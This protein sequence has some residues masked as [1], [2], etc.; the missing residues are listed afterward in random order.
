MDNIEILTVEESGDRIDALLA[1]NLPQFSRSQIQKL[2]EQGSVSID[3]APLKK[4]YRCSAGDC[5]TIVLPDLQDIPLI[6]QNIPLDI[7]FEE[8]SVQVLCPFLNWAIW[9][10]C[11]FFAV[12][13]F[14][15]KT[16][17]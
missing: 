14:D 13:F 10:F 2:L 9:G 12:E 8:L 7:V 5:I 6:P 16:Q 11:V 4:N 3:E 15:G 17:I 1:R